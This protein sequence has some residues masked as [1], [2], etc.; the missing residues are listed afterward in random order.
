MSIK[1]TTGVQEIE[2]LY[3][4]L[5]YRCNFSCQ[6]CFHGENLKRKERVT[7]P[8][9]AEIMKHFITTYRTS[10]VVLLGGEPFLH[11]EIAEITADAYELGL[12]TEI[13]TNGHRV[14]RRKLASMVGKLGHLRISLD[15]L[16]D[17][18]DEI[19]VDGSFVD[20]IET[21]EH[22]VIL[23]FRIGVTMT[24]TSLN[25]RDLPQLVEVL[26]DRGVSSLKLHQ[27]RLVGN[28]ER[29][30]HLELHDADAIQLSLKAC[31]DRLVV[32]LD[33]DL[34]GVTAEDACGAAEQGQRLDRI[35]MSPAGALTMSCK[36]VG[37]DSHAFV[38][39]FAGSSVVYRPTGHDEVQLGIPQVNYVTRP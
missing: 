37:K 11:D 27:L 20:A 18:H 22:A 38:W 25:V 36:A 6:H 1:E 26:A 24:V 29:N 14:A 16:R 15:G 13:C 31:S 23:G 2:T 19:R 3:L 30:P 4:Q 34:L 12:A 17:A 21:I 7:R 35:E 10:K 28:A 32:E 33:D 8:Q 5:L 39:D 9:A